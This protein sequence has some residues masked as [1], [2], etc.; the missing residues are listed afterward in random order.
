MPEPADVDAG[1]SG[2]DSRSGERIAGHDGAIAVRDGRPVLPP[3]RL[4]VVIGAVVSFGLLL[5]GALGGGPVGIDRPITHDLAVNRTPW[6]TTA[7]RTSTWLGST[8]TMIPLVIVIGVVVHHRT[9]SWMVLVRLGVALGGTMALYDGVK[10]LVNR[11]RPR[12][13]PII[14]T[15]S[16]SS[17]PSGHA[18]QAA[19]LATTVAL[20]AVAAVCSRMGRIVIWTAAFLW[21][22][23][24]AFTRVYL[25]V[26]WPTDVAGGAILGSGWAVLSGSLVRLVHQRDRGP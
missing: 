9:S 12:V 17:F 2:P 22:A 19:T 25:G 8:T 1:R 26:H 3:A 16:G 23:V 13:A 18:A 21:V 14:S 24:I 7:A 5:D 20:L 10:I 11:P 6:L 4:A 15:A